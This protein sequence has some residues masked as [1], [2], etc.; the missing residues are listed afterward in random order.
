[1]TATP[2]SVTYTISGKRLNGETVSLT[3]IQ[4]LSFADQGQTGPQGIQGIQ[5]PPGPQGA[6]GNRGPGVAYQGSWVSSKQYFGDANRADVVLDGSTYYY[7]VA[8]HTSSSFNRP[9]S[10]V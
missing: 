1:M 6:T 3:K 5:G 9:P 10:S 4:S 2:A 8:T 7:C